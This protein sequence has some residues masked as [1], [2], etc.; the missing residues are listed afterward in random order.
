LV[1]SHDLIIYTQTRIPLPFVAN[2]RTSVRYHN[3]L[4]LGRRLSSFTLVE[5]NHLDGLEGASLLLPKDGDS[6]IY[7]QLGFVKVGYG[8]ARLLSPK[9]FWTE[10]AIGNTQADLALRLRAE[11]PTLTPTEILEKSQEAANAEREKIKESFEKPL[12][13]DSLLKELALQP[14]QKRNEKQPVQ[15]QE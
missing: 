8:A 12:T 10:N 13:L 3:Q 14:P 4:N 15:W 11:S 9:K 5:S 6:S 2:D 1:S 7:W